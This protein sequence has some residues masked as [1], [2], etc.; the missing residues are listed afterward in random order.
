MLVVMAGRLQEA[1]A[2]LPAGWVYVVVFLLV[3]AEDA[4]LV[5]FLLPGATAAILGGVTAS[6]GHTELVIMNVIVVVAAIVGDSAGYQVGRHFGVRL[7]NVRPL[8]HRRKRLD[9]AGAMLAERGGPAV[10]LARFVAFLRAVMPFLAGAAHMRYQTFLS[11]NA[12][13]GLVWGVSMVFI[14][15]LA[16]QSYEQVASVFGQ[17]TAIVVAVVAIAA[18]IFYRVRRKA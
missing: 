7:L 14:G 4:I 2:G 6:I 11:W 18:W 13:A 16:G 5:G 9:E 10:F 8:E 1:L 12:T 15:Y 17:A 3:F